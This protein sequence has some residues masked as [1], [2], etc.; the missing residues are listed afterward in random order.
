MT[1]S[2]MVLQYFLQFES[3]VS[4]FDNEQRERRLRR[5]RQ[6]ALARAKSVGRAVGHGARRVGSAVTSLPRE[7]ARQEKEDFRRQLLR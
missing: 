1:K 2:Q 3:N 4:E 5:L 7:I 6:G